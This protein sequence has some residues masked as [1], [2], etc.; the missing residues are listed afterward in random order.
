LRLVET[1]NGARH[2]SRLEIDDADAVV[3]ELRNVEALPRGIKREMIDS[4]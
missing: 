4:T 3:T 2:A 1:G